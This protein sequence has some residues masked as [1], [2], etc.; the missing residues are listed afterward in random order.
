MRRGL[1]LAALAASLAPFGCGEKGTET[2]TE[3]EPLVAVVSAT[4][5]EGDAPLVVTA[6][7]LESTGNPVTYEWDQDFD[8]VTF[9]VDATGDT[10]SFTY[11][12]WGIYTLA[13]RVT[14][15]EATTDIATVTISVNTAGNAMPVASLAASPLS[16]ASPL[17]VT[18]DASG[19]TDSDGNIL[20]YLWDF[21]YRDGTFTEE[22]RTSGP[23]LVHTFYFPGDFTVA[24][25]VLD[26]AGGW[27]VAT[28]AVS[29]SDSI[30]TFPDPELEKAVR[31]AIGKDTGDIYA[32]DLEPVTM[33]NAVG[34]E[35]DTAPDIT[36]LTNIDC[37]N[38][39]VW[40][41]L[42]RNSISDLSPLANLK[43]L[44]WLYIYEN[45]VSD[46]SPLS[47]LLR[48]KGLFAN[49]NSVSSV[50]P[51]AALSLLKDLNLADN[52]IADISPLGG[53]PALLSLTI[54][55]NTLSGGTLPALPPTLERLTAS[56]C[57]LSDVSALSA[58][59]ALQWLDL[60]GNPLGD[61]STVSSLTNLQYLNLAGC[62]LS[63]L[64]DLTAL[65]A[66]REL[67]LSYN[68][69]V[70]DWTPL[71]LLTWLRW[72]S[73][74]DCN[75][76]DLSF[77][78]NLTQLQS[79]YID[80]NSL[81]DLSP[82]ASATG[83]IVLSASQNSLSDLSP[84]SGLLDLNYLNLDTNNISEITPLVT[85]SQNGGLG[86]GDTV[87]LSNNP[88]STNAQN[89]DIPALEANGVTV[90]YP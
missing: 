40:L 24:V 31:A 85:N 41:Y 38:N 51:L 26:D 29:V 62:G 18:L 80:R 6:S 54:S 37:L 22:E 43:N 2:T 86:T 66:L 89:N 71:G 30:V 77:L 90:V 13:L 84:L 56:G 52:S 74:T 35:D 46:L 67:N 57:G 45:S 79:L 25:K 61:A 68:S 12:N 72:L 28:V 81:T 23:S 53:L 11:N 9:D 87:V 33:L 48:L 16:G 42:S 19:S 83:L 32:S 21:D 7:G 73:L 76:S 69:T 75:L 14:D 55:G 82:L 39:L 44:Q 65:T 50:A 20:W 49:L 10:V 58:L 15:A 27:D 63:T 88:L 47:G 70:S 64:P 60:S 36:D 1:W 59:G 78:Q 5:T 3:P 8:G 17:A 4:P 34:P